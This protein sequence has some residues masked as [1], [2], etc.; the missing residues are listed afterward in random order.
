MDPEVCLSLKEGWDTLIHGYVFYCYCGPP[1]ICL[2]DGRF[3]F[4][5]LPEA[6]C[7]WAG[8]G[9]HNRKAVTEGLTW[10]HRGTICITIRGGRS[11]VV[12]CSAVQCCAV[13]SSAVLGSSVQYCALHSVQCSAEQSY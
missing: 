10:R 8:A 3:V 4:L 6:G 9:R 13:V 2:I 11:S 7:A 12:L 1:C 5:D